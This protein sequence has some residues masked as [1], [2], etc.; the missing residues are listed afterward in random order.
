MVKKYCIKKFLKFGTSLISILFLVQFVPAQIPTPVIDFVTLNRET[1]QVEIHWKYD[2]YTA[3]GFIVKRKIMDFPGVIPGSYVTVATLENSEIR[4]FTD[5]STAYGN[6]NPLTNAE[7]YCVSAYKII[8]NKLIISPLSD[9]H[10]T[11][12]PSGAYDYCGKNTLLNF[13]PYIG[14]ND[15]LFGY[16]VLWK[17]NLGYEKLIDTE[18]LTAEI[19]TTLPDSAYTFIL[20]A[21][22][23][24]GTISE[25]PEFSA[26]TLQPELPQVINITKIET[27]NS[28]VNIQFECPFTEA[29]NS[30]TLLKFNE[31]N[32]T[33]V[34]IDSGTNIQ[35]FETELVPNQFSYK[36]S[37]KDYCGTEVLSSE[38]IMVLKL[39]SENPS[40]KSIFLYWIQFRDETYTLTRTYNGITDTID[41]EN[42]SDFTE[43][44]EQFYKNQFQ[45]GNQI[46]EICYRLFA[47]NA[48]T[49]MQ[50]ISDY[51]CIS[52]K[53][54]VQ[55]PNA[56]I[57]SSRNEYDRTFRVYSAFISDFHL[58]IYDRNGM[59]MFSS[60]SPEAAW[61]GTYPDG[62]SAPVAA[63]PYILQYKNSEGVFQKVK[64]F[65]TVL[66]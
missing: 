52:P 19:S 64:G 53:A 60:D 15:E 8:D 30:A 5:T 26:K 47:K 56:L 6:A 27:L 46:D 44:I 17:T 14:W 35:N 66:D 61:N 50:R 18:L 20:Q 54:D 48:T 4:S 63:Y 49:N 31:L 55:I 45:S 12:F 33:Y 3:D 9:V 13:T 21:K 42:A 59:R 51:I 39:F 25:S 16:S 62:S 11:I 36:I 23:T 24:D 57:R 22:R 7:A 38:E 32:G 34:D 29:A 41:L 58:E 10:E 28:N 40:E 37:I 1:Q 43:N 65:V 2:T